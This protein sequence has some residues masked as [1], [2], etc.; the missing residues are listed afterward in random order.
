MKEKLI[1]LFPFCYEC[2]EKMYLDD[3]DPISPGN[4][5]EYWLCPKCETSC[6]LEI[7]NDKPQ[8]EIWHSENDGGID[9]TVTCQ[10]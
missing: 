1:N 9:F 10:Y 3:T 2:G 6:I 4:K 8:I 7:R 5:D